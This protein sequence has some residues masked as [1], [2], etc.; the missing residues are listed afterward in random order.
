MLEHFDRLLLFFRDLPKP[1]VRCFNRYRT[2]PLV[3]VAAASYFTFPFLS[4]LCQ[5][6]LC[7]LQCLPVLSMEDFFTIFFLNA[8]SEK[9]T[10]AA[11]TVNA[12]LCKRVNRSDKHVSVFFKTNTF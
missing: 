8:T 1:S 9:V 12:D 11:D 6:K 2:K 3:E 7:L 10:V 5:C 4:L